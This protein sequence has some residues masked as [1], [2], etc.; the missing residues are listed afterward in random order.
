MRGS[1][2]VIPFF[3]MDIEVLPSQKPVVK[4]VGSVRSDVNLT[5]RVFSQVQI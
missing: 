3:T 1:Y 2:S 5:R 4:P